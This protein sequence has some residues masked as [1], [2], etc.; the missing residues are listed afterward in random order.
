MMVMVMVM[1]KDIL[2]SEL[3]QS[4]AGMCLYVSMSPG[5]IGDGSD[6]GDGDGDDNGDGDGRELF[7]QY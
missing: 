3:Q 7:Y 5:E 4:A 2:P 6:D 1:V